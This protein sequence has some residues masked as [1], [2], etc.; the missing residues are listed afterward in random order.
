MNLKKNGQYKIRASVYIWLVVGLVMVYFQIVIGGITRLT[1]SGL[2]ITEWEIVTGTLPPLNESEWLIEFDKYKATPQ[3]VKINKGME[4]GS[5]FKPGTFKFIYFWEYLH[6][7]WA[8]AMGV[9]F[10]IP[11]I[12]FSVKKWLPNKLL[13]NLGVVIVLSMLA[14]TFGWIM[15]ASGLVNRPWVN[16]YKLAIH[17]SIG[18]SVYIALLWALINYRSVDRIYYN[19]KRPKYLFSMFLL[20]C[21]Q[22]FLGGVMS[23]TKASLFINSW[24]DYNGS[25]IPSDISN[26]SNWTVYNFNFYEESGFLVSLIQFLHRNVAYAIFVYALVIL[27]KRGWIY[28]RSI[29]G[30]AY[31][32]FIILL[33]AQVVIGV[34]T[35][36]NSVGIVP[37]YY[38]VLHQAF[39]V[40]TLSAFV[41][42]YYYLSYIEEPVRISIDDRDKRN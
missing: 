13:R 8:R 42:H 37:V 27:F 11:F 34:L 40:L 36:I 28:I 17:L 41:I 14:A 7:L 26:F 23:G 1:G 18:I 9:V 33:I 12:F 31:L 3:Y 38:G 4:M 22:I 15:V 25:L 29:E 2:S 21:V 32:S 20:L 6:R 35:L 30:R 5:I 10:L 24:P 19:H 16:A 39:A